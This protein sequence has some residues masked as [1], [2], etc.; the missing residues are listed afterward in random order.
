MVF[1]QIPACLRKNVYRGRSGFE[2]I[3]DYFTV[4]IGG[5]GL[6]RARQ[7]LNAENRNLADFVMADW[8]CPVSMRRLFQ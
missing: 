2:P 3:T 8:R 6:R 1:C 7:P 5:R 4:P